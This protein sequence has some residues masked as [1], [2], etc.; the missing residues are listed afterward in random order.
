VPRIDVLFPPNVFND[1]VTLW[2]KL[3]GPSPGGGGELT[4]TWTLGFDW[5][6]AFAMPITEADRLDL[7]G[8]YQAAN[9]LVYLWRH[10]DGTLPDVRTDD[11]VS[12]TDQRGRAHEL[13][14]SYEVDAAGAGVCL[15]APCTELTETG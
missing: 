14:V 13:N 11:H 12:Y 15:I 2:P 3:V 10:D 4:E 9:Y 8:R 1:T 6:R 5:D 7:G